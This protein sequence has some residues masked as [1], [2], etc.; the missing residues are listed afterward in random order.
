MCAPDE[1]EKLWQVE[2][3]IRIAIPA[4]DERLDVSVPMHRTTGRPDAIKPAPGAG[5]GRG[6]PPARRGGGGGGGGQRSG[7]AAAPRGGAASAPRGGD[8]GIRRPSAAPAAPGGKDRAWRDADFREAG[9]APA[10]LR[11]R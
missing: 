9:A 8:A 3:L 5:R 4:T 2:K 6:G 7:G 1:R 10:F 11:K